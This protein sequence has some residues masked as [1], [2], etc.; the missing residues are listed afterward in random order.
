MRHDYKRIAIV[1]CPGSGKSTLARQLADITALPVIHLDMEFW[2]PGWEMT[3]RDEWIDKQTELI[4]Q[5]KWIIDG[6]YGGTMEIRFASADVVIFLD[7]G[8]LTCLYRAAKRKGKRPDFPD[9]LEEK[10]DKDFFELCKFIWNYRKAA[11]NGVFELHKKYRDK[12]FIV[13]RNKRELKQMLEE[14][15][16]QP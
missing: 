10:F 6:N 11:R 15:G 9:F 4:A 12:P 8:R 16:E 3:P 14:F 13:I 7:I 5:E 1:G 2:R